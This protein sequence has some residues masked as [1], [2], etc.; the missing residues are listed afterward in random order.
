MLLLPITLET[1][2]DKNALQKIADT[3]KKN[4]ARL[5]PQKCQ[6][7]IN[8]FF[9]QRLIIFLNDK[10]S[11]NVL[12]ACAA[13]KNP[14]EDL[15]DYIERVKVISTLD[16]PALLEAANRVIRILKENSTQQVN[17]DLFKEASEGMLYREIQ[18][19][20]EISNYEKYLN[21]LIAITPAVE[22]FFE[23]V[24]VMDKD[25]KVKENRLAL[26]TLL[27]K[28]YEK[29]TDFSKL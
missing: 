27:K 16:N 12:E 1:S 5:V 17:K 28:K 19:I 10:Y 7:E 11:K 18:A 13:N 3:V 22:K 2:A 26:L 29:L 21:Q 6:Q 24:L 15:A 14:M 8:E 25:E 4:V 23:D 9:V 20:D